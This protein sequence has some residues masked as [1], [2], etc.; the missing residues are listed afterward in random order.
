MFIPVISL[1]FKNCASD[2]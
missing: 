1:T 2:I